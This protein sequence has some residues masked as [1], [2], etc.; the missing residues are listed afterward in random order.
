MKLS[1]GYFIFIILI[2]LGIFIYTPRIYQGYT[3]LNKLNEELDELTLETD[4]LKAQMDELT[5]KLN[6]SDDLY[7]IESFARDHLA[8]KKKDETIYRIIYEE[9]TTK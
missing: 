5:L 9:D 8:M 4:E 1:R 2:I 6:N 3:T 7:Y